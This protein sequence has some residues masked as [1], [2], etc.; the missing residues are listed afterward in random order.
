MN[1]I[2]FAAVICMI[3][4]V[5]CSKEE[6]PKTETTATNATEQAEPKPVE[7]ESSQSGEDFTPEQAQ[8]FAKN[9]LHKIEED[10]KFLNDAFELK[11]YDT[12]SKYVLNDWPN[13]INQ[14]FSADNAKNSYGRPYF[15]ASDI[16]DPYAVCDTAFSDLN[17]YAGAMMNLVREDS[18]TLRKIFRK[19]KE[20]FLKSKAQCVERVNMTYDEAYEAEEKE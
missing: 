17:L 13:Y 14:P 18:A 3:G 16:A 11:E 9:L 19:E 5:G 8:A 2:V 4:L 6:E 1:K 7:Q 10:E 12:L 20:D 15:P